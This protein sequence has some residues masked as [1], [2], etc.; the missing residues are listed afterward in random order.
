MINNN[1][2]LYQ[3]FAFKLV[4]SKGKLPQ[5]PRQLKGSQDRVLKQMLEK[6]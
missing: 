1:E 4:F 2:A 5:L 6:L 3:V